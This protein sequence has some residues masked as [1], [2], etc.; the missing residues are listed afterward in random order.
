MLKHTATVELLE[1]EA[2]K[3]TSSAFTKFKYDPGFKMSF[4]YNA[5]SNDPTSEDGIALLLGKDPADYTAKKL[6]KGNQGVRFNN[7]GLSLHLNMNKKISLKDGGGQTLTSTKYNVDMACN[8]W[9][10]LKLT[11]DEDNKLTLTQKDT[12]LL[13]HD[14]TQEQIE[15]IANWPIGFN[16][17][18]KENGQYKVRN[19]KI[20]LLDE[21][22]EE[23]LEE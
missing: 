23:E 9:K 5:C 16:A 12:T 2:V 18:S 4:G 13:S 19:V 3:D 21:E 15:E 22:E 14:L 7:K 10:V 1:K 11:I 17:F 8:E 6:K 20:M